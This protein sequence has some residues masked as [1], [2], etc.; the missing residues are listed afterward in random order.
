MRKRL[1]CGMLAA[2]LCIGMLLG[3]IIPATAAENS[4]DS[5]TYDA[6]GNSQATPAPYQLKTVVW[7]AEAF[8]GVALKNPQDFFV[9]DDHNIYILDGENNRVVM[10]DQAYC[11]VKAITLNYNGETVDISEA[12]GVFANQK[13]LYIA[14][15]KQAAVFVTDHQGNVELTI[16]APP[17]DK[18]E[19][20]FVYA[21]SRV[22]VGT[23]DI[24]YIISANTY[25]GAL[26]YDA[27]GTF[28]GFFGS[29]SVLP[30][31]TVRLNQIWRKILSDEAAAG[32][33]R[34]VPI[35]FAQFD[36]DSKNFLYTISSG[37]KTES[38]QV[39]R[40]NPSSVNVLL[41]ENGEVATY[42]DLET[43]F[44]SQ[45]NLDV[46]TNFIDVTIDDLGFFT[47]L[48]ATRSRLFQYDSSTNLLYA[49]GIKGTQQG[50]FNKPVAVE[51]QGDC[52]LVLDADLG[53]IHV[54][55]PTVFGQGVRTAITLY[56]D[57]R[58]EDAAEYWERILSQDAY[59]ALANIGM[60]KV[61]ERTG[62]FALA[63]QYY[64]AGSDRDGYSSA[65]LAQREAFTRDNFLLILVGVIIM[66]SLVVAYTVYCD[67]HPINHYE[68]RISRK[69]MPLWCLRHPFRGFQEMRQEN[70]H[71]LGATGIILAVW[72]LVSVLSTQLT[73]FHF[74]P[75]ADEDLNIFVILAKTVGIYALFVL[76]N[77]AVATLADGRGKLS[78][79]AAYAAY[80][81]L[82]Y[83][84]TQVALMVLS[85][86][87]SLEEAAFYNVIQT[88]GF[89]CTAA[90]LLIALREVHDYSLKTT[91]LTLVGTFLGMYFVLLIITIVYSMFAQL[92]GFLVM[93]YS[94]LR[95]R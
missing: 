54:L 84:V 26:Q 7:G 23:D 61:H 38:G 91:L 66:L 27:S 15:K 69:Q 79:I 46:V 10:L 47:L 44:N 63:M 80:A 87:F 24:I 36:I 50:T 90:Y 65:F 81:L 93:L 82:P 68:I 13:H 74:N 48:D 62:N 55:Q 29:D 32:L 94:E 30:T 78:E 39:R 77:W 33:Q 14:D 72:F 92:I 51:N 73:A 22:V 57:G 49:F 21:P 45:T 28:L 67:R 58:Y 1:W 34:S 52:I 95:L 11:F 75:T 83:I 4:S 37:T 85:N 53:G 2:L 88:V 64:R 12:T 35:S 41:N 76:C 20:G 60:G 70:L 17:A 9:D 8:G 25:N 5:Y 89:M 86:I 31:L 3:V 16:D 71:S 40:V 43:W 18:V 56:N 42:G 19:Q 6:E 59:Y